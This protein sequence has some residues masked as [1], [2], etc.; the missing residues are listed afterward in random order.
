MFADAGSGSRSPSIISQGRVS[1]IVD[2]KPEDRRRLLEDAAGIGGLH[3]R[4][5]EAE[6]KLR[7]A[8]TNLVRVN[9]QLEL[10]EK[11]LGELTK[12]S[13]QAERYAKLQ[14]EIRSLEVLLLLARYRAIK[15]EHQASEN[16]RI[17]ADKL[18]EQAAIEAATARRNHEELAKQLPEIRRQLSDLGEEAARL[19]ERHATLLEA[20]QRREAE[21][22]S[23]QS[24]QA[25]IDS[26]LV[27]LD[28]SDRS[29][30]ERLHQIKADLSAIEVEE[31][32]VKSAITHLETQETDLIRK[33]EE[34]DRALAE[35]RQIV[36]AVE[37]T[38]SASGAIID[39]RDKRRLAVLAELSRLEEVDEGALVT[40]AGR[41]LSQAKE[42][43]EATGSKLELL[44]S[45][46]EDLRRQRDATVIERDRVKDSLTELTNRQHRCESDLSSERAGLRSYQ[47]R[48]RL[49]ERSLERLTDRQQALTG[50]IAKLTSTD[51]NQRH[52]STVATLDKATDILANSKL[53]RDQLAADCQD[54]QH[55]HE[56]L[57]KKQAA[58]RDEI[59]QALVEQQALS[60]LEDD[61]ADNPIL[62]LL[63]ISPGY[64]RAVIAA[65]GDELLLATN[66][67]NQSYWAAD[68][69]PETALLPLPKGAS[70]LSDWVRG[71]T[72]LTA[73]LR[74]IGVIETEH[75]SKAVP[76][77]K[78]GQ[79]LV[80]V[81]GDFWRWD[82]LVRRQKADDPI[83]ARL[84]R[85]NRL[86]QLS[87]QLKD[88]G[89]R[90]A[91]VNQ[92]LEEL[93]KQIELLTKEIG[94]LNRTIERDERNLAGCREEL[95]VIDRAIVS[96]Q[97]TAK[98][99]EAEQ[100]TATRE[101]EEIERELQELEAETPNRDHSL[102][103]KQLNELSD[104]VRLEA[105]Q[106]RDR[107]GALK[108]IT[109][110]VVD[111][112]ANERALSE[113]YREAQQAMATAELTFERRQSEAEIR[114]AHRTTAGEA[115]ASEVAGI[116]RDIVSLKEE[117]CKL[118]SQRAAKSD[119]ADQAE[120]A[121]QQVASGLDQA[122]SEISRQRAHYAQIVERRSA[123]QQELALVQEKLAAD[124][125]ER[126]NLD[127]TRLRCQ[128]N[129]SALKKALQ[130]AEDPDLLSDRLE[131]LSQQRDAVAEQVRNRDKDLNDAEEKR[132]ATEAE[133]ASCHETVSLAQ[134]E[135]FR[136]GEILTELSSM[137]VSKTQQDA[138]LAIAEEGVAAK[139]DEASVE[140]L[141]TKLARLKVSRERIGPVNL[142]AAQEVTD[143][144]RELMAMRK[145]EEELR[146]AID[147]LK[148]AISTLNR[149]AKE[150]LSQAFEQ[151]DKHFVTLFQRLFGGG[152]AHLRLTNID[153]PLAAGL[154][155]DAM[156][157]GKKLQNMALL[158]GG[159][160]S[161]T[162][163]ALVFAF[164][165]HQPSPLCILDEVDAALDDSNV[166]RFVD[167]MSEIAKMTG[168]R[169]LVVTHHP[170]TMAKMDRLFGV[171]MMEKGVS[172]LMSVALDQA[173]EMRATA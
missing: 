36:A 72:F 173:V 105:E 59:Q 26:A 167:L 110:R 22:Q 86:K 166:E 134:A 42:Q 94:E 8:E 41:K 106:L 158:S 172:R 139:L 128:Q 147:R 81:K 164:F 144:D 65:L 119:E 14:S 112:E 73:R 35:K 87:D 75:A 84:V 39:E 113:R 46:L 141:E 55:R 20:K 37:A 63:T 1:F 19:A 152:K 67:E 54:L 111:L 11:R 149:E 154:E 69:T 170:L 17:E 143:L 150:R 15:A 140:D 64:E 126:R 104:A 2:S 30:N 23:L 121:R 57:T 138:D 74:S 98:R 116:E 47:E 51:L 132:R 155:L 34:H 91:P 160:K 53:R 145:D 77:L 83:K 70:P 58:L 108:P 48:Q 117:R 148:R 137:V 24:Q 56:E 82:S 99:L 133:K 80:T 159:E 93:N 120:A 171:T 168:T 151:V 27:S 40:V 7:A 130:K 28:E 44:R 16:K 4:R 43:V 169:F 6:L 125:V 62:E 95:A 96:Q 114:K 78:A 10:E 142:R 9:D 66:A 29:G 88:A 45:D 123:C 161:L 12:Q 50:E 135:C 5:R 129:E 71:P 21:I 136:T 89:Q 13:R 76:E 115:F 153:D 31:G 79:R 97:E 124:Q 103:E 49:L 18:L 90:Q 60:G 122:R 68:R 101:R 100:E 52:A 33:L 131:T 163:L 109:E 102:L 156:P 85:H 32:T 157:P 38:L 127:E 107:E 92:S 61:L 3:G 162:A 118:E 25:E 165:L 146:E